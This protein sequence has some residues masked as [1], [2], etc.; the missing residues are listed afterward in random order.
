LNRLCLCA[1]A[2]LATVSTSLAQETPKSTLTAESSKFITGLGDRYAHA[3]CLD[4]K[5]RKI[6][7]FGGEKNG[8]GGFEFQ[9]D[10]MVLDLGAKKP[11]WVKFSS[12]SAPQKR[13]YTPFAINHKERKAY[14]F[15]GF[16]DGGRMTNDLWCFSMKDGR[17]EK[18]HDANVKG[19]PPGRD[20]HGLTVD[21][22]TGALYLFGGLKGISPMEAYCDLWK[23]DPKTKQWSELKPKEGAE[24]PCNRYFQSLC[25]IGNGKALLYGGNTSD[26]NPKGT[27]AH[28]FYELELKT[29]AWKKLAQ[30]AELRCYQ[31]ALW[32]PTLKRLIVLCG[33]YTAAHDDMFAYDPEKDAWE[34]FGNSGHPHTYG[35]SVLDAQTG[36]IYSFGGLAEMNFLGKH[37]MDETWRIKISA[38]K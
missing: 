17:W 10:M 37:A 24:W 31:D 27:A 33:G 29:G 30:P 25:A 7:V 6:Y 15:G 35:T 3:A 11:A 13:A 14:I 16:L 5:S 23:F 4:A 19:A 8:K 12:G 2:L 32:H 21:E 9:G 20:A 36:D 26:V 34:K 22:D 28:Y 1:L 38:T 18:I